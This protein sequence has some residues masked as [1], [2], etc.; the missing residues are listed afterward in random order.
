[1]LL[2][3]GIITRDYIGGK[4]VSYTNPFRFLLSLAILY[5]LLMG[6]GGNF[7]QLNRY[8]EDSKEGFMN[9]DSSLIENIDFGGA[10]QDKKELLLKLDSLNIS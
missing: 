6:L 5:F 7:E 9:L 10:Q 1:M 8:G 2:R 3:P 4:R